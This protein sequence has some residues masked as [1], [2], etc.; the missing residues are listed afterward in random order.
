[1]ASFLRALL[2]RSNFVVELPMGLEQLPPMIPTVIV[3]AGHLADKG[4]IRP[5]VHREKSL[6]AFTAGLGCTLMRWG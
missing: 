1:M 3:M 4:M 5:I 6:L 2:M